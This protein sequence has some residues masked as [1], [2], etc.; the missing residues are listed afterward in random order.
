MTMRFHINVWLL[1]RLGSKSPSILRIGHDVHLLFLRDKYIVD[2]DQMML[3]IGIDWLPHLLLSAD[4][5]F[6]CT[7]SPATSAKA[8]FSA[9]YCVFNW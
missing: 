6:L 3:V 1:N 7:S 9:F 5:Y 8:T 4:L 2:R